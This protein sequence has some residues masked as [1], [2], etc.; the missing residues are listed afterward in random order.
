MF[1]HMKCVES[2]FF[3]LFCTFHVYF[4]IHNVFGEAVCVGRVE[5]EEELLFKYLF[6]TFSSVC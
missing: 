6:F 1:T 5:V 2:T 3:F 4:T